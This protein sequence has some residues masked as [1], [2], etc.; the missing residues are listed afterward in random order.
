M[1]PRCPRPDDPAFNTLVRRSEVSLFR[2]LA[3][4]IG[5]KTLQRHPLKGVETTNDRYSLKNKWLQAQPAPRL[6]P[7]RASVCFLLRLRR[8]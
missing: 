7:A 5:W 4:I 3:V 2:F 1:F 8:Q 6:P